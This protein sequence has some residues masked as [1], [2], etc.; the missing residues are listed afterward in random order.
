MSA[1]ESLYVKG[2]RIRTVFAV[3]IQGPEL[4]QDTMSLVFAGQTTRDR[5]LQAFLH[6]AEEIRQGKRTESDNINLMVDP[7]IVQQLA[8]AAQTPSNSFIVTI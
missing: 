1:L 6:A 4:G 7:A 2:T 3:E 5:F 8:K